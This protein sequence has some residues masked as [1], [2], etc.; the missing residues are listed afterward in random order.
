MA[1]EKKHS[2][3]RCGYFDPNVIDFQKPELKGGTDATVTVILD[4]KEVQVLSSAIVAPVVSVTE[5]KATPIQAT[6][7]AEDEKTP[8]TKDTIEPTEDKTESTVEDKPEIVAEDKTGTEA[9]NS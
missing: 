5:K 2:C 1:D 4:G 3:P 6:A 8:A 9:V 7:P